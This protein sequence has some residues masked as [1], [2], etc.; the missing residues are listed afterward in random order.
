MNDKR[1]L[2]NIGF[3]FLHHEFDWAYEII[4]FSNMEKQRLGLRY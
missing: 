3:F 2:A 1:V 4:Y